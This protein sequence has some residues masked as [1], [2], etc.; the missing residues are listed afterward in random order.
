MFRKDT[1][2]KTQWNNLELL[3]PA[4]AKRL[5][6]LTSL[7]TLNCMSTQVSDLAPLSN[8]NAMQELCFTSTLVTD[9]AP[10][11]RLSALQTL[12]CARLCVSDFAPLARLAVVGHVTTPPDSRPPSLAETSVTPAGRK[13]R[14]ST[15]DAALGPLFVVTTV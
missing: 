14:T 9:L 15:L 4:D 7:Q 13:S 11:A 3:W 5:A 8:L 2:V 12:Y 6:D 1:K 10:L